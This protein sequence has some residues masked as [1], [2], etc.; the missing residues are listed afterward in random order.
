MDRR[1]LS[2][3]TSQLRRND[4]AMMLRIIDELSQAGITVLPQTAFLQS[5]FVPSGVLSQR[6]PDPQDWQDIATGFTLAKTL[7]QVD[8]GQTAVVRQ[9][10]AL[11]LEA[12]EGT[13]ACLKRAGKLSNRRGGVVVKVAKPDQDERFD[14]PAVGL[15][16]L[17]TMRKVGLHCLATEANATFYLEQTEMIQYAN[18]HDLTLVSVDPTQFNSSAL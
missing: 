18:E 11:A 8:V 1:A 7:G 4:D 13:D 17:K 12:I 3:L 9:G 5:C 6:Q 16:T 15:R 2:A 10:M 14:V